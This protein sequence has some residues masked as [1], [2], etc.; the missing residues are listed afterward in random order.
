MW[1]WASSAFSTTAMAVVLPL[2]FRQ[3]ATASLPLS[4]QNLST[5]IWGYTTA[6][7]M[8]L[9]AVLSLI[10]GP[11]ADY[12]SSKKRF[13]LIYTIAGSVSTGLMAL[14][15]TG[16]WIWV[17][18][19]FIIASIGIDGG[20]V[21]YNSLLPHIAPAGE[22]DRI[23]TR[24][25]AL[26]YVGGGILLTGNLAMMW[27]LP[28]AV[29][30]EGGEPVPLLAMQ[31]SLLSVGL[32]WLLFAIPLFRHVPEPKG[33]RMGLGGE[34]PIKIAVKRLT[35]TF[36]DIRRY[37]QLFIFILAYWCYNDG[38]GTV[39]KMAV[40]YGDEIGIGTID[41]AGA[42]L[43]VQFVGIPCTFLFGTIAKRIGAKS[44]ILAGIGIYTIIVIAGYF[45]SSPIH[46]W[47]L[48]FMV[49]LVQGGTQALSRSLFGDMIP[50]LKSAEFFSFY[51][52][53]GKF[54]GVV[55]PAVFALV[56]QLTHSSR[57]GILALVFFFVL[58]GLLLIR[59]D[60]E[61][62]KRIAKD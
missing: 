52:I 38:I 43:L 14:A 15:G 62:G 61:A 46:F 24:G 5:S 58:G 35:T 56:G 32:W 23:S 7:A 27:L 29:I 26:G 1:D 39:M 16:D 51:N 45:I 48:A 2:F 8:L 22:I 34:N 13:L 44:G 6:V 37:R 50:K 49:G 19:L 60:V 53:S 18:I 3:V 9:V 33:V 12:G 28:K 55:G 17:A 11:V 25:Y 36:K 4:H 59:V 31:L 47:I 57:L 30:V 10:M 40:A 20:E 54:A 41:L 21:F 42:I